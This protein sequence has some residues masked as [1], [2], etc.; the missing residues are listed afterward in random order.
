M[1]STKAG[2]GREPQ[3]ARSC[4]ARPCAPLQGMGGAHGGGR[5]GLT[6]RW[7]GEAKGKRAC[8][9]NQDS[10]EAWIA[11]RFGDRGGVVSGSTA[12]DGRMRSV[13]LA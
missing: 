8:N 7:E 9:H 11:R 10:T 13:S 3:G 2:G 6:V 4:S 5:G 1:H 12:A